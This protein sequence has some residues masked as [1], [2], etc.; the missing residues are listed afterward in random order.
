MRLAMAE[1]DKTDRAQES[2]PATGKD[3]RDY[4]K[5]NESERVRTGKDKLAV[6]DS[7]KPPKK[8]PPKP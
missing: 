7:V 5:F 3:K 6:Y 4:E 1:K 2:V 8:P